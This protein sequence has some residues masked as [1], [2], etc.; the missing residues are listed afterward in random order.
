MNIELKHIYLINLSILFFIVS[1]CASPKGYEGKKLDST[2]L[3]LIKSKNHTVFV[4]DIGYH[5]KILF[6]KVDSLEVGSTM[7]GYPKKLKVKPGYRIL[8][9]RHHKPWSAQNSFGGG[10]LAYSEEVQREEEGF[11]DHYLISFQAE[12]NNSYEVRIISNADSLSDVRIIVYNVSSSDTVKSSFER[13]LDK[14]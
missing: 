4:K 9:G 10:V 1:G 11:Y 3:A 6:T 8:E 13:V 5:E 2:E 12:K 7:I 14:K